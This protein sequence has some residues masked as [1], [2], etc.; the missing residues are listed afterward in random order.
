M[1]QHQDK[2][3]H[4]AAFA[5]AFFIGNL[6]FVGAFYLALWVLYLLRYKDASDITKRHILQV[7]LQ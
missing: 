3:D 5:Q 6:L 1:T 7:M 4:S 2:P